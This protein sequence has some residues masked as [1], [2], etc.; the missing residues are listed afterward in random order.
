MYEPTN[1]SY[2]YNVTA[3]EKR[4]SYS[5]L[6]IK[7]TNLLRY[8]NVNFLSIIVTSH[9]KSLNILSSFLS[10]QISFL[11]SFFKQIIVVL[12]FYIISFLPAID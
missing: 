4:V 7:V 6:N 5:L 9:L 8:K 3:T 12:Y 11:L 2:Y 1:N 10:F